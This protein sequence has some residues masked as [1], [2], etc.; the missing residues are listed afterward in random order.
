MACRSVACRVCKQRE[1]GGP[2]KAFDPS[3]L[4][5]GGGAA[6]H[7]SG[8][9]NLD[10]KAT[11]GV[12]ACAAGSV[13]AKPLLEIDGPA[14]VQRVVAAA[15][16]VHPGLW[17]RLHIRHCGATPCECGPEGPIVELAER[18]DRTPG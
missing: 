18:L 10:R 6:G 14:R 3:L 7:R 16:Y 5:A 11:G 1:F 8:E 4:A 15:Q 12:P 9:L 17:H 2:R 13:A